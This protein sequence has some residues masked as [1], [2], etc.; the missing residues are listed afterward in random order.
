MRGSHRRTVPSLRAAAI[1]GVLPQ[2]PVLQWIN[3]IIGL[4]LGFYH[5]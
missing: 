2:E 4:G 1:S 3:S 5:D